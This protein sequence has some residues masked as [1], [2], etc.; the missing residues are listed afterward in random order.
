MRPQARQRAGC[1]A[2]PAPEHPQ[3]GARQS[4]PE[5]RPPPAGGPQ[6]RDD[7]QTLLVREGEEADCQTHHWGQ[8][9]QYQGNAPAC[10]PSCPCRG[11]RARRPYAAA[12]PCAVAHV[13]D[14]GAQTHEKPQ[15]LLF[16]PHCAP[17]TW[18]GLKHLQ[19]VGYPEA[20]PAW[21]WG[22]IPV[23]R[24]PGRRESASRRRS[25]QVWPRS[26]R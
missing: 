24:H 22:K 3:R 11:S 5:P 10:G 13:N 7:H 26:Y 17:A 20:A 8:A 15:K 23:R 19:G 9:R 6:D 18:A 25:G 2:R 14:S 21:E 1:C 4:P 12:R 16:H